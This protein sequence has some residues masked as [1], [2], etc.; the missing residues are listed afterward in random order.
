MSQSSLSPLI[1]IVGPTAVGKT[2]VAIRLACTVG[3]EIICADSRTQ[4]RGMDIGTAKPS[5]EQRALIPHHLLDLIDPDD[6]FTLAQFQSLA[7]RTMAEIAARGRV[8]F[9]VGGSGLYVKAI[10]EG[11]RIPQM[12]PDHALRREFED[13]AQRLGPEHLYAELVRVDPVSARRIEPGNVRRVIRALEVYRTMGVPISQLQ[14][15]APPPYHT[16]VIGLTRSLESLER[17]I[18]QRVDG[19]I[20]AGLVEE[21]QRLSSVGYGF[22]L[23][24][25]SGI[26]YREIGMHLRGEIDLAMARELMVRNTRRFVRRQYQWFRLSDPAIHWFNLDDLGAEDAVASDVVAFLARP[27]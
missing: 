26:G 7:Y 1:A 25:L 13:E 5:A 3:G 6:T 11:F 4:Y 24:A 14:A 12:N 15:K 17:A 19:M 20:A 9:L 27:G 10:L 18:V 16:L 8:P 22:E 23:P 21:V 2:G